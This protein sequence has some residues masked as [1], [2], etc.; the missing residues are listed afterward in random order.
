MN[1]RHWQPTALNVTCNPTEMTLT[2]LTL[3]QMSTS[4]SANSKDLCR[5]I[6][7][8]Y[9]TIYTKDLSE[10]LYFWHQI[11]PRNMKLTIYDQCLLCSG[12]IYTEKVKYGLSYQLL[13][14]K[15]PQMASSNLN[16]SDTHTH[17]H[18]HARTHKH[19]HACTHKHSLWQIWSEKM[20]LPNA[21]AAS[22]PSG[23]PLF[24]VSMA[25]NFSFFSRI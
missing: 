19:M 2:P 21:M 14:N 8:R 1:L 11:C 9:I 13:H 7:R 20:L 18:K 10:S 4:V 25:V 22:H 16:N 24:P 15:L 12:T 5:S 3:T 6:Q 17:T 23:V